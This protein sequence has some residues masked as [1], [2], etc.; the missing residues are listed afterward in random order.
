[1]ENNICN[2]SR[3]EQLRESG[4][5]IA[6]NLLK[7]LEKRNAGEDAIRNQIK[8]NKNV[9]NFIKNTGNIDNLS[10]IQYVGKLLELCHLFKNAH[11]SVKFSDFLY[12]DG[13]RFLNQNF[14]YF[15][16]K[17]Y[18]VKDDMFYEIDNIGGWNVDKICTS[19]DK[20]ISY[21]TK[22]W[23]EVQLCKMLNF[24]VLYKILG[25]DYSNIT[26][27]NGEKLPCSASENCFDYY[28]C[29]PPFRKQ[30]DEVFNCS[31][32]EDHILR[33]GYYNCDNI[34]ADKFVKLLA[35]IKEIFKN[36]SIDCYILDIRGNVG[37]NSELIHPLL[38]LLKE[39]SLQGVTL[40]DN[41]VFSSGT[42]A[43]YYIKKILNTTSIGQPLGQEN[44]RFGQSSGRIILGNN[45]FIRYTEKYFDF[46]DVFKGK[47]AIK[48]DIEV[49]LT[50]EDISSKTDKTLIF[51]KDYLQ[52]TIIKQQNNEK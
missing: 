15:A 7:I 35:D 11:I 19:F 8:I 3:T 42:F 23:Q 24:D 43:L 10:D 17:I 36:N 49:P 18:V 14:F 4:R 41:R 33:I 44:A 38:E 47:G 52:N 39:K 16:G 37:G 26:L 29:F 30:E 25:I 13:K 46:Q 27:K 21:E 2:L 45:F 22:E 32:L 9:E 1:M 12:P 51:A 5:I 48:P 31:V 6:E 20:Y 34:Y 40:T 28:S 50:I